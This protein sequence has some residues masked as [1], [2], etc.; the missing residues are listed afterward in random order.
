MRTLPRYQDAYETIGDGPPAAGGTKASCKA[1]Q[2]GQR[3]LK[4]ARREAY[5]AAGGGNVLR[6][7]INV[8]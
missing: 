4:G 7:N 5:G 3:P 1:A 2:S 8:L 6:Q